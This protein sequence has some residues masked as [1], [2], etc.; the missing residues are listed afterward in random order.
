[1]A[2]TVRIAHND[3]DNRDGECT[4]HGMD[5][6]DGNVGA[7]SAKGDILCRWVTRMQMAKMHRCGQLNQ[8]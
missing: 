5:G 3:A 7:V 1:M 2:P 4:T 8:M 6:R